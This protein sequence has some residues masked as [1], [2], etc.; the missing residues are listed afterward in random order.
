MASSARGSAIQENEVINMCMDYIVAKEC[1]NPENEWKMTCY[2][3]GKCGR[4]FE[5][6][7]MVSDGGTHP[8]K[9]EYEE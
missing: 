8:M 5:D 7:F 4:V 6:G 9:D 3:C 2:K 1:C